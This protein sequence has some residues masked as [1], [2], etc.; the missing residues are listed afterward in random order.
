MPQVHAAVA[1]THKS[2]KP[3]LLTVPCRVMASPKAACALKAFSFS[4][5]LEVRMLSAMRGTSG[6][7]DGTQSRRS[8]EIAVVVYGSANGNRTRISALKGP[9]ANRCTIAPQVKELQ[10]SNYT[11]ILHRAPFAALR[12]FL[13]VFPFFVPGEL[14]GFEFALV[15]FLRVAGETGQLGNPLVHVRE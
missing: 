2:S 1:T 13:A 8:S 5:V 11:G 6:D 12:L 15:G 14:D 3:V 9:R 4:A 10:S 7:S